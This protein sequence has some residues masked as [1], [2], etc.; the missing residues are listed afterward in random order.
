[1]AL[2][3][4]QYAGMLWLVAQLVATA[5]LLIAGGRGTAGAG[6]VWC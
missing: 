4:L 3:A 2:M 6:R 5:I 1:M